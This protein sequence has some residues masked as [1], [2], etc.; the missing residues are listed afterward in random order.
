MVVVRRSISFWK[1]GLAVFMVGV[2]LA[3]PYVFTRPRSYRSETIIVY[4][5]TMRSSDLTG[6]EGSSEGP[7]RVGAR[8]REL[9]LSRASLEPIINDLNLYQSSIIRGELIGAVEEMRKN[10]AFRAREGDTYEISFTGDTPK[11]AQEVTRRLAECV[12]QETTSRR[13]DQAKTLK[14]FLTGERE[15]NEV[16]L[17]RKEADLTKFVALHPEYMP[18]LQGLPAQAKTPLTGQGAGA[19]TGDPVL[20]SLQARA[21]RIERQLGS[22][23]VPSSA[24]PKPAATFQPPPDSAELVAARRDLA[25][26][27][28]RFTDKHPDVIAA[29]DRLKTAEAAQAAATRAAAAAYAAAQQDDDPAPPANATDEAALRRE[30]ASLQVRMAA[31]RAALSSSQAAPS[32]AGV[33]AEALASGGVTELEIE[34][35][36]L[37]RE[38]NDGRDRQQQ[39]EERLFRA[40]IAASSVMDDR[41][42]QVSVLDPAYLPVR[43]SSKPR[44]MLLA[45]LLAVSMALAIGTAFLSANLDDRIYDRNDIDRLGILPLVAIIPKPTPPK[46]G[47]LQPRNEPLRR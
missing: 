27:L 13:A 34:F 35:R 39:L 30:L 7:R 46:I 4:Q 11:E 23:T 12:I 14:E 5:E 45:A 15:R 43:P 10:I 44:S 18:R 28:S 26:K 37:Q 19:S 33:D 25:D 3:V 1:R 20:S 24:P 16:E 9:L 22:K 42:I 21:A 8:L 2:L 40:S 32:D 31:R 17:Q 6:N 38:V 47:Q 41:N 36:R 29:R